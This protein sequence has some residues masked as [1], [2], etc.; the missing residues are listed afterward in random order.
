VLAVGATERRSGQ[1]VVEMV[2]FD[3]RHVEASLTLEQAR[4]LAQALVD[5]AQLEV[6]PGRG[7]TGRTSAMRTR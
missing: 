4:D 7:G 6:L 2:G 5:A 3:Q 1:V